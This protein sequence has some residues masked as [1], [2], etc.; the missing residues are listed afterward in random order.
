MSNPCTEKR[1]S[2]RA[3]LCTVVTV[4]ALAFLLYG[5]AVNP[6]LLLFVCVGLFMALAVFAI[7]QFWKTFDHD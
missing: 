4:V 1:F 2:V 5:L 7:Y 6:K 3:A